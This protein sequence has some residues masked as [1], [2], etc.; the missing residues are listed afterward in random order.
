MVTTPRTLKLREH[1]RLQRV[2]LTPA[3]LATI[4]DPR[5]KLTTFARPDGLFDVKASEV[6]G[7]IVHRGLRVVIEPKLA[8]RRLLMLLG[9]AANTP[10][11]TAPTSADTAVDTLDAMALVY[12]HALEKALRNGVLSLYERRRDEL[13][14]PRGRIDFLDL[15]AR[16][17]GVFPPITCEFDE[18]TPDNEVNRR[19]LAAATTLVRAG[20]ARGPAGS[21]IA[22]SCRRLAD[23]TETR[24]LAIR[25]APLRLDR[26]FEHYQ[27]ALS[28]AEIILRHSSIELR[29]GVTDSVG[30]LVDMN[31]VYEDFIVEGLRES[32]REPSDRW[33]RRPTMFL[34][35][36]RR[37]KLVP[38]VVWRAGR[39][40]RL[41]LDVKYKADSRARNEDIYQMAA[42][43][44]ALGLRRGVLV[45]A[46]VRE[47]MFRVRNDG[48]EIH[49]FSMD[50]DGE[51]DQLLERLRRLAGLV[52]ALAT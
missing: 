34:D 16:K 49:V 12:A 46:S 26:R 21:Q 37:V 41:V 23:V 42:Y 28:L 39:T 24:T 1:E 40:D 44:Q 51:R 22:A 18:F 4:A 3:E 36:Q 29:D 30:M 10:T 52:S 19:L 14:T 8:I 35:E 13:H 50:P 43:C 47:E 25:G 20:L 27:P 32:L 7:T 17:F 31:E 2:A 5:A 45:Y 48:P 15:S 9:F 11:F 33:K 38:D 6:V